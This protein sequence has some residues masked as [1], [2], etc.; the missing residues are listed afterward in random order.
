[1]TKRPPAAKAATQAAETADRSATGSQVK[2][3]DPAVQQAVETETA[4]TVQPVQ[5]ATGSADTD[6]SAQAAQQPVGPMAPISNWVAV[7]L[8]THGTEVAAVA[9]AV[10]DGQH[11]VVTAAND[12]LVRSWLVAGGTPHKA[13]NSSDSDD[14]SPDPSA[15]MVAP[16]S[17]GTP[18]VFAGWTDG[19][20]TA[21]PLADTPT[22]A[23]WGLAAFPSPVTSIA[24]AR[25]RPWRVVA[26][27]ARG[28]IADAS[29]TDAGPGDPTSWRTVFWEHSEE[30]ALNDLTVVELDGRTE[31]LAVGHDQ[32]I[33]RW[34]LD[35]RGAT[36]P[37]LDVPASERHLMTG[38]HRP[39]GPPLLVV[40]DPDE[41]LALDPDTYEYVGRVE[42]GIGSLTA[43]GAV[44]DAIAVGSDRG[45][46]T[47]LDPVS[48]TR[49][50]PD[51]DVGEPV[52]A[53]GAVEVD[54]NH[55]VLVGGKDGGVYVVGPEDAI[56]KA[57]GD[58]VE[59]QDDLPAQHA[60]EDRLRRR[61]LAEA[62]AARL[63][64]RQDEKREASFLVH[65]DG[66]WG[67]GKT[68]V[69]NLLAEELGDGWTIVR[70]NAWRESRIGPPWWTLF[71]A[72]RQEV[73]RRRPR[74]RRATLWLK[75]MVQQRVLRAAGLPATVL[76][77]LIAAGVFALARPN[78][79][80]L[81]DTLTNVQGV[82][83]ALTA[84]ATLFAGAQFVARFFGWHSPRGAKA[85]EDLDA[86]PMDRVADHFAWLVRQ[87]PRPI[88]FFLDDLDRCP[89]DDVVELLE[90]VQTL[91]RDAAVNDG[92]HLSPCFVVAGDGAWIR[93]AFE[94]H[95]SDFAPQMG[96]A[97]RPLGYLFLNKIF[98]LTLPVPRV[99]PTRQ[100]A[101]FRELLRI[102][103]HQDEAATPDKV[104]AA[105]ARIRS[106]PD[107][108]AQQKVLAQ[109]DP[110]VREQVAPTA[111]RRQNESA[112]ARA[113]EHRLMR[114]A[115][116][117]PDNPR[118]VKRFLNAFAMIRSVR[119][120]E[121]QV[122]PSDSLALWTIL[123]TRWP[124][125]ADTLA[126]HPK[127][128]DGKAPKIPDPVRELLE[129]PDVQAVLTCTD[130]GPLTEELITACRGG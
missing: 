103:P 100:E 85:F 123:Q 20:L 99:G 75:E 36:P 81:T 50:G 115:P 78:D 6:L 35:P 41:V 98:Q 105:E 44:G 80:K 58:A 120:L 18:V 111:V 29:T 84:L 93:N 64:R 66:Q 25:S 48:G 24:C 21:D 83:A 130:G 118:A 57:L 60:T 31:L 101:Y 33:R 10:L 63:R 40:A 7:R 23:N 107:D 110:A 34:R 42:P 9:G 53:L 30:G 70:Y 126:A 22:F 77:L 71:T 19:K 65:L 129:D 79:V 28:R 12:G 76:L 104:Q 43:L 1:M 45:V 54:G 32:R 38:V 67:S 94:Q 26:A 95:Y 116:L 16:A 69:L 68:T 97:G 121:G 2:S 125:L 8:A 102:G 96:D 62:L 109:L 74:R 55:L 124:L 61:P 56:P 72:M 17:D 5:Q 122:I 92:P 128:L 14:P 91:V 73:M 119:T 117:L 82:A 89:A 114:Y 4:R 88:V 59:L 108:D 51:V 46:V 39:D 106:A 86:N 11:L 52:A 27:D 49:L 47:V 87:E 113:T 127:W 3:F 90:N 112:F 15:L 13:W 37:T